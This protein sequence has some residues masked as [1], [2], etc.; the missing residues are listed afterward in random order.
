LYRIEHTRDALRLGGDDRELTVMFVDVRNFTEISERLPPTA[1]VRFLNTLLDALSRHVTANEGT[2][3]KFIGDSIM[4]FWNA[5]V[6]V[7]DHPRKAARAALAMRETIARLNESDAFGFGAGQ[8]VRIGIGIHTGV[9]CVGN[10]G[11]E[12]RF[13]YSAV[14]DAV[15]IAARIETTCKTV[16]FDILASDDTVRSL[17]GWALLDAGSLEL[18][19]KSTRTRINAVVGD[20]NVGSSPD[21]AE[22]RLL[23]GKLVEALQSRLPGTRKM[24]AAAK[25][26]AAGLPTGLQEFYGRI[27]RRADDFV[28][29]RAGAAMEA[30]AGYA[31]QQFG[32]GS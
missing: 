9:A 30:N 15:N 12:S 31:E 10:M 2:L 17:Q 3:D 13:N 26:K 32:S 6:D 8:T 29:K 14:G 20:E 27:S 22:L 28:G 1:V 7:T 18:K 25:V 24:I 19:G 11:A 23:H 4:A 5:P 21:F 16:S